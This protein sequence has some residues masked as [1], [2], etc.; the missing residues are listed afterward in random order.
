M[1]CV[2]GSCAPAIDSYPPPSHR[3]SP[4]RISEVA[5]MPLCGTRMSHLCRQAVWRCKHSQHYIPPPPLQNY[6]STLPLTYP[7]TLK[8][9]PNKQKAQ[10]NS[11]KI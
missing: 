7:N 5:S 1:S 9:K 2:K 3:P 4:R 8:R 10:V 11:E 6:T